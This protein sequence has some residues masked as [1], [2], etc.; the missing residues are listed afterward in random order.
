MRP[1]RLLQGGP[2]PGGPVINPQQPGGGVLAAS[3][4]YPGR[5]SLAFRDRPW[6]CGPLDTLVLL[7]GV[8]DQVFSAEH[9]L[10]PRASPDPLQR[11]GLPARSTSPALAFE[12]QAATQC[13]ALN[14]MRG[15]PHP[16]TRSGR[17]NNQSTLNR[18]TSGVLFSAEHY[19]LR[20]VSDKRIS[21]SPR[22]TSICRLRV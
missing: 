1:T 4:G 21:V 12:G 3:S 5:L 19:E 7:A 15:G 6:T 10:P 18:H 2:G 14:S 16:A 9:R 20:R 13:S 11:T 8:A 22:A 17:A